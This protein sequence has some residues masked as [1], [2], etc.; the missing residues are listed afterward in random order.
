MEWRL[1][2]WE[3]P[4]A[5]GTDEQPDDD[6]GDVTLSPIPGLVVMSPPPKPATQPDQPEPVLKHSLRDCGRNRQFHSHLKIGCRA[7]G[8]DG[9]FKPRMERD[10]GCDQVWCKGT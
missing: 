10:P 6:A 3:H 5:E 2:A 1:S 9:S 8:V 4:P 7:S